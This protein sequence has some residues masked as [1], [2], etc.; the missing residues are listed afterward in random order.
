M[1]QKRTYRCAVIGYSPAF[2]MGRAHLRS[3]TRNSGME[4]VAVCE[5]NPDL[6]AAAAADW[7]EATIYSRVGDMLRH[8]DLDLVAV[9]TPHNTHARLVIQ[10]LKAGVGV[11]CEKPLAITSREI[12]AM[13]AAAKRSKVMLSTFHN[14]RW[15]ADFLLLRDLLRK[16]KIIGDVFRIECGLYGYSEQRPWWRS[17]RKVSGGALFDWGAHFTD[18]VLQLVTDDIDWVSGFQIKNRAWTSYSN[19]DHSEYT[20][21]FKGGCEVTQTISNLYMS[22][23]PRWRLLGDRGAIEASSGGFLVRSVVNGRQMSAEIPVPAAQ[24]TADKYYENVYRHLQGRAQLAVTPESAA[25]VIGVLEAANLSAAR[26][27][28]PIKPSFS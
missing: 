6:R 2:N 12:R 9:I 23:R 15:D 20:L 13:M 28:T 24:S 1:K 16:E 3:M 26:G 18:W 5:L 27:S 21:K 10:C 11:V 4:A 14:R 19:E 7:P 25:R 22:P 17:D 8:A